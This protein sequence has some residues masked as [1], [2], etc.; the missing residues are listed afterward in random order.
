M[1]DTHCHLDDQQFAGDLD[2]VLSRSR[3][4]NV[5]RWVLIGYNPHHWD[6]AIALA[7]KHEGMSHTL[8]VHPACA[9]QWNDAVERRLRE[10]V[11]SSH[12]VG[13]GEAG[14]DFYRDNAP[15]DMQA[16]A[17]RG[18]LEVAAD[19]NLPIVIHMRDAEKEMLKILQ[20]APK[21]PTLIFHS[22]D[23]T[24][25]LMDFITQSDSYVGIGGLSTRQ[26]SD[27][28]RELLTT[29]SLDRIL[30]ETDSPYL[31]PARQ[32]DRRNQPA[33]I[34]TIA[35]M[36]A[37]HLGV[38]PNAFAAQTTMNAEHVFGLQHDRLFFPHRG[39]TGVFQQGQTE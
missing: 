5:H 6:S 12:A 3:D 8:G 25:H 19:L 35:T 31:V 22:F 36:M 9:E 17:F 34:A 11:A 24:A 27:T 13:I 29:V 30:L 10:L 2:D 1:I 33:N 32:K 7:E 14:L 15:F 18:Q 21:L 16:A 26:K 37:D 28:L 38:H 39:D 23:G 4:A 20:N